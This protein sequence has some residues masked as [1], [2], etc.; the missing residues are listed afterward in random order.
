ARIAVIAQR[1]AHGLAPCRALP[2][3]ADVR[4]LG[5]IGVVELHAPV[6]MRVLPQR[7]VARGVWVRPFGRLVYVMPPYI[8]DDR[9]LATLTAA[10]CE[11]VQTLDR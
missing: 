10:I 8:I 11:V 6:D 5:A 9:D 4:V 2:H 3:V 7:F 1:L